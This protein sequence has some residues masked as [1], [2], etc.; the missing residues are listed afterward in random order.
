MNLQHI[1]IGLVSGL[2]AL[3]LAGATRLTAS[4]VA[5]F[6]APEPGSY[7][8]PIIKSA[9]NGEVLNSK[10]EALRLDQFTRGKV[11]VM[12]F[13]YTRCAA[14]KACPMATGVLRELRLRSAEDP[15][16][17]TDLR[18]VSMSFDPGADTPKRMTD[19]ANLMRGENPGAEWYFLTTRSQAQLQPILAAY[20]QAVDRK[21]NPADP[22]GPLNHTLRVFLIDRAGNIRNIYSSGTLD[23]RLVLADIKTLLQESPSPANE[24]TPAQATRN[25]AQIRTENPPIL[26]E[27]QIAAN[28]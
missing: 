21:A 15:V 25:P 20:G 19:Y 18:L 9:A 27:D 8:L 3:S 12:S 6:E 14:V 16:L 11:T 2:V 13:I 5:D 23:V 26:G 28:P 4:E 10:G 24:V 22:T 17:A 7:T 1:Q